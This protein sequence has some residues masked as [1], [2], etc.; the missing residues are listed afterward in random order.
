MSTDS[1]KPNPEQ[2]TGT[3]RRTLIKGVAGMA[4]AAAVGAAFPGHAA[5][6]VPAP[7][8]ASFG[9]LPA[10]ADTGIDH[11]VVVMMEN[12]SFDHM[13]GWVP[14]AN[15]VQAG[16][17]FSDTT[18]ATFNSFHLTKLENCDS[19]DPDH[20]FPAGRTQMANGA[21]SG[22]LL[23][24]PAGDQFPIGYYEEADVPFYS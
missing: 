2:T 1:S 11:V 5:P 14:G 8:A 10:P 19:A 13:L 21:M 12:R 7:P 17:S 4:G 6:A 20:G 22:F 9:T 15:G 3:T 23:T 16:R 18:G 24:Q